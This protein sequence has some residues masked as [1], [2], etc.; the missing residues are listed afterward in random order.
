MAL[1]ELPVTFPGF[2]SNTCCP[3]GQHLLSTRPARDFPGLLGLFEPSTG[4]DQFYPVGI[5][6]IKGR[7][8]RSFSVR[9]RE[10]DCGVLGVISIGQAGFSEARR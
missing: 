9:L 10:Q 5:R 7:V 4:S 2:L 8:P 3:R 6:A 1:Q